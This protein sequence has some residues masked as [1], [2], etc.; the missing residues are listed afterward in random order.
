MNSMQTQD[1]INFLREQLKNK[2]EIIN[3]SNYQNV[4]T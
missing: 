2:D 3:C 1:N 4:M